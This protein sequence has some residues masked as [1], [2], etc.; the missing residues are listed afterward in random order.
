MTGTPFCCGPVQGDASLLG[1]QHDVERRHVAR[2]IAVVDR[3]P[4]VAQHVERRDERISSNPVED[5]SHAFRGQ[6][7]HGGDEVFVPVQ[8]RVAAAVLAGKRRL[9]MRPDR[10]DDRRAEMRA[11]LRQQASHTARRRMNEDLVARLRRVAMV[12]DN[13]G[14]QTLE[15]QCGGRFI[16]D[17]IR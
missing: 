2:S 1:Q 11:P 16:A 5:R 15:Q 6:F 13:R 12:D 4:E 17:V 8:D 10:P 7:L 3:R 14:G 9:R